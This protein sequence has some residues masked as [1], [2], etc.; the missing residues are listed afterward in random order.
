MGGD[1]VLDEVLAIVLDA[2]IEATGAE[3]GVILLA[4]E[5][6]RWS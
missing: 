5:R 2:A 3:R 4:D 6:G 1:R